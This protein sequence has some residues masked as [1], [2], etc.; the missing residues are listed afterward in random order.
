MPEYL[1]NCLLPEIEDVVELAADDEMNEVTERFKWKA[2]AE[3][4]LN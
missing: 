2:I 1:G 3:L 4:I